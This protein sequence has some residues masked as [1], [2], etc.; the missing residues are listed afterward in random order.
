MFNRQF[1]LFMSSLVYTCILYAMYLA[2]KCSCILEISHAE[3]ENKNFL[4]FLLAFASVS[5]YSRF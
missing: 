4:N 2:Y 3:K 5:I 1:I